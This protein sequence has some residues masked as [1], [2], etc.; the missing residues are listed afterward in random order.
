[1]K[2]FQKP[3]IY[4]LFILI[5][6]GLIVSPFLKAKEYGYVVEIGGDE[7]TQPYM[8]EG[9]CLYQ[10]TGE[11]THK[12]IVDFP[13]FY[14]RYVKM[15][16]G[17]GEQGTSISNRAEMPDGIRLQ[18]FAPYE[19]QMWVVE[20]DFDDDKLEALKN[21]EF[22][23]TTN[24][25]RVEEKFMKDDRFDF[26]INIGPKGKANVWVFGY[27]EQ[28]LLVTL[29]AKK[30]AD[31]LWDYYRVSGFDRDATREEIIESVLNS[32][33]D[34][35][36]EQYREG[37]L[38]KSPKNWDRQMRRFNWELVGNEHF[39]L[40]DYFGYYSNGEQYSRY[41]GQENAFNERHGAPVQLIA[42]VKG[43]DAEKRYER[44]RMHLDRFEVLDA[45]EKL[46]SENPDE[47]LKVRLA[48]TQDMSEIFIYV[49]N[50][51]DRI[52]IFEINAYLE[53]L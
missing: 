20:A 23:A 12:K 33:S 9:N 46:T 48:I 24:K 45:F 34:E 25:N 19:N 52:E 40:Q 35:F 49:E 43:F 37:T 11:G 41:P 17:M 18:W 26:V 38:D 22:I 16:M 44:V 28:Y 21:H 14:Y 47:P 27:G 3:L 50:Q 15:P 1:M 4:I 5:L 29:Q 32:R 39:E 53:N 8:G 6:G 42:F 51:T 7:V 30:G 36:I 31:Y 13:A 10:K 2:L